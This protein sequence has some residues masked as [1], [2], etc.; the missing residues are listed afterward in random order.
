MKTKAIFAATVIAIGALSAQAAAQPAEQGKR[1][2]QHHGEHRH[3]ARGGGGHMGMMGMGIARLDSDAD[4]R[5]SRAEIESAAAERGKR[6]ARGARRGHGWLLENFDAIDANRD[7]HIVRA[8]LRA[9]Q[10]AQRPQREAERERRFNERFA[11]A[12]LNG[13]GR[14]SRVEVEEKMPRLSSSFAWMDD[15]GDGFLSREELRPQRTR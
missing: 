3:H 15:N 14:L 10:Q 9:W 8:E 6:G 7:G 4:G 5:I 1:H 2:G 12:D 11:T 13:D